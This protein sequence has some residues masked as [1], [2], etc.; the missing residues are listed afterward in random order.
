M[1]PI[2]PLMECEDFPD[3]SVSSEC[4]CALNL[5]LRKTVG[6]QRLKYKLITLSILF[7]ITMPQVMCKFSAYDV[8]WV[9]KCH[10]N[11]THSL[12]LLL[13]LQVPGNYIYEEIKHITLL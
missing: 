9:L 4:F 6:V 10:T 7:V 1:E 3:F 11:V 8:F 12:D 2:A 13:L 5:S